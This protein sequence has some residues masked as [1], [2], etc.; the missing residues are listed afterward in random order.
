MIAFFCLYRKPS[1]A[2]HPAPPG[3]RSCS[4]HCAGCDFPAFVRCTHEDA[5]A[6]LV[7]AVLAGSGDDRDG[8]A[9]SESAK[10]PAECAAD[11]IVQYWPHPKG[12]VSCVDLL[13]P[14][15]KIYL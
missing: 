15:W 2:R 7:P 11:K 4:L 9:L 10:M 13:T 6:L 3:R 8:L 12:S 1:A 14:F 5:A